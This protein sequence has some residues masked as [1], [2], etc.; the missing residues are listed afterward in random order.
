VNP[1]TITVVG[2]VPQGSFH[3]TVPQGFSVL[4]IPAPIGT[5]VDSTLVSLPSGDGDSYLQWNVTAQNFDPGF[6]YFAGYGWYDAGNNQVFPGPA[7]GSAFFYQHAAPNTASNW[8]FNFT[9]Q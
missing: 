4:T 9:V 3:N 5:N 2:N 7:V 6:T 1:A 8:V